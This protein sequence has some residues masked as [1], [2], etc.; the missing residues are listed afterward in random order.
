MI[1]H[2]QRTAGPHDC[3]ILTI[4]EATLGWPASYRSVPCAQGETA[5]QCALVGAVGG[6]SRHSDASSIWKC[7]LP[8]GSRLRLETAKRYS[9]SSS[10]ATATAGIL[11]GIKARARRV[12]ISMRQAWLPFGPSSKRTPSQTHAVL[13]VSQSTKVSWTGIWR[14]HGGD[15]CRL[16]RSPSARNQHVDGAQAGTTHERY[17]NVFRDSAI[18]AVRSRQFH[19]RV[20]GSPSRQR[21][22][23]PHPHRVP[24]ISTAPCFGPPPPDT[25]SS[26]VADQHRKPQRQQP[27]HQCHHQRDYGERVPPPCRT[28]M[29]QCPRYFARGRKPGPA[30]IVQPL[31][32][33][34]NV[35]RRER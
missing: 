16:R 10:K 13:T 3:H 8:S 6:W 34:Q 28:R 35:I 15:A 30:E 29:Q 25:A 24:L 14:E 19:R 1:G 22:W 17:D 23:S 27:G 18:G 21:C 31:R 7:K 33:R 11:P 26:T 5:P 20:R 2:D 4:P 9:E 12:A 32:Y